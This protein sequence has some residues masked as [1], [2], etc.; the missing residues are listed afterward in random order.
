MPIAN[1]SSLIFKILPHVSDKLNQLIVPL[2]FQTNDSSQC[3]HLKHKLTDYPGLN[4]VNCLLSGFKQG[5]RIGYE[6]RDFLPI[7][8]NTPSAR[9]N[10]EQVTTAIIKKLE[11]G[12]TAGPFIHPPLRSSSA[13]CLMQFPKKRGLTTELLTSPPLID[14]PSLTLSP[15]GIIL[16]NF[17]NLMMWCLW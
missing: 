12:H 4:R 5:F 16:K 6:G 13:L 7:T 2:P 9:D 17:S 11:R 3:D 1:T 15:R 14:Y 8:N 10:P